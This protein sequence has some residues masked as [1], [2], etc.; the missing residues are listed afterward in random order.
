MLSGQGL[1]KIL[2]AVGGT[3]PNLSLQRTLDCVVRLPNGKRPAPLSAA[4]LWC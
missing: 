4:E 3:P 1:Q 2:S